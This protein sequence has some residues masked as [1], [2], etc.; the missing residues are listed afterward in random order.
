M[1]IQILVVDDH[2]VLRAG[3]RALLNAE[4]DFRVVGEAAGGCEA[5]QL[6]AV[7][8]PEVVLLDV[9]MPD[10]DG[11]EVTRALVQRQPQVRVLLLTIH[12]DEAL[13]REAIQAGA[14]GYVV[15]RAAESELINAIRSAAAGDLYIHPSMT[16]ALLDLPSRRP[17]SPSEAADLTPRE[18]DVLQMLAQGYTNRQIAELLS[19][20]V[21]T[22]E[23]HRANLRAKLDLRSRADLIRY[24]AQQG[25]L[26]G[27]GHHR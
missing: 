13:V 6:A 21:R 23:T 5:L 2:G 15:K 14:A 16:R 18:V 22:V 8:K 12:E 1:A 11:I 3:L 24:A 26:Q 10:M 19:L 17:S 25:L 4:A 27:G 7:L 20:S 9:S